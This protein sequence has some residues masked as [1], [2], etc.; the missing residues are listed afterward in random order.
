MPQPHLAG[1]NDRCSR[2]GEELLDADGK[3]TAAG[4]NADVGCR[5]LTPTQKLMLQWMADGY[6][7][8]EIAERRNV[9]YPTVKSYVHQMLQRAHAR[10]RTHL[11]AIAFR[12]GWVQ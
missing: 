5:P 6:T 11:V 1:D 8:H 9:A 2:C 10:N 7:N 12:K 4:M 3:L